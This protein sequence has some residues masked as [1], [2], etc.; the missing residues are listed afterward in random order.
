VSNL[1]KFPFLEFSPFSGEAAPLLPPELVRKG[2]DTISGGAGEN[3]M[4]DFANYLAQF[5]ARYFGVRFV[6]GAP[7]W[8]R[9]GP[10]TCR[11][12]SEFLRLEISNFNTR[13]NLIALAEYRGSQLKPDHHSPADAVGRFRTTRWSCFRLR[14]RL[15]GG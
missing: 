5:F 1:H 9:P 8:L 6:Q 7:V 15:K 14:M 11:E 13:S 12:R 2:Y 4:C 10:R 3:E